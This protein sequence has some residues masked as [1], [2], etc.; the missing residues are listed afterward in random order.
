V[1][2]DD[3]LASLVSRLASAAYFEDA[4]EGVLKAMFACVEA[5]LD[6]TPFAAGVRLLRGVVHLRPHG[7]YHRIF[8]QDAVTDAPLAGLG[9]IT[10]GNLWSWIEERRCSVSIDI[11]RGAMRSWLREGPYDQLDQPGSAGMPGDATRERMLGRDATHVHVVPLL[12]PAGTIDGMVTLEA[13]FRA[14]GQELVWEDCREELE[15][16]VRVAGAFIST[17]ALPP[18]PAT[19]A[20]ADDLMPVTGAATAHLIDL[21]RAFAPRDDTILITGPTGAGKS[22]LARWCHA[23]SGRSEQPFER[24]D[25]L[26]VPEDLQMAELFGW[27]RGAFTGAVKD[28]PGAIARAA[29][30]T[31]FLDEIDKLSLKAQAGLLHFLE[32]RG[33]RML[34]DDAVAERQADVRFLVGTNADLRAAVRAGRF[35]EDL[36]YRI[37]VLPVRLPPLDERLDELPLWAEYML[38]R[39]HRETGAT[40]AARFE[41]DALKALASVPWPGNLRQLDNIVRRAYALGL[42]LHLGDHDLV[43]HR[44]HVE[45]ALAIDREPEPSAVVDALWRA[46]QG[47]VREALR[48]S[49]GGGVL[50]LDL[51]DAFRGFA[52]VAALQETGSRDDAFVLLGKQPLLKNRNHHRTL[53]RE[54]ER[55]R[56]LVKELGGEIDRDLQATLDAEQAADDAS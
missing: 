17:R 42:A 25:L 29:K 51:A 23:H 41:P 19:H 43:I 52:L 35:R 4:A 44:R 46:A 38:G 53:R 49:G 16:L 12:A 27:K 22:R 21:L 28:N 8:G 30:G 36:Y 50:S 14:S 45:R 18:R 13:S 31:L 40:G 24:L 5:A 47:F 1:S 48:R 2:Q 11:Q 26:G 15:L 54:L 6:A 55:V 34:G 20:S 32:D 10:S 7:T 33:Y 39:R 3:A 56:E 9:Y 37:N